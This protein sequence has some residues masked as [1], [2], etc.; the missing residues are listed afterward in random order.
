ML[1][2]VRKYVEAGRE[3]LTPQK[4]EQLARALV[5]QGQARK[6]QVS[7]IARDLSHWSRQNSERLTSLIRREV[8]RQ[9]ANIGVATRDDVEALKRRLRDLERSARQPAAPKAAAAAPTSAKPRAAKPAGTRSASSRS[10]A[11]RTGAKATGTRAKS[12]AKK[13]TA[14]RPTGGVAPGSPPPPASAPPTA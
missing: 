6:D 7:K 11:K 14:R 10:G 5:R 12:T 8:K 9:V 2:T 3:A 4:A 13:S 1:D